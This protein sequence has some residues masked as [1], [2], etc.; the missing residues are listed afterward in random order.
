MRYAVIRTQERAYRL[1][2]LCATLVR[3]IFMNE[4]NFQRLTCSLGR[5]SLRHA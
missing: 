4:L 5:M 2:H 1:I 3:Y